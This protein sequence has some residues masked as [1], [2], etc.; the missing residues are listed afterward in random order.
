MN[1]L[2]E[3]IGILNDEFIHFVNDGSVAPSPGWRWV[4]P[5][6]AETKP[7]EFLVEGGSERK[8]AQLKTALR[9]RCAHSMLTTRVTRASVR[10]VLSGKA[11]A[12]TH[13]IVEIVLVSGPSPGLR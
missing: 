6:A 8:S 2:L 12:L 3:G 1:D 7:A 9:I 13:A 5:A 4:L 11:A 10:G